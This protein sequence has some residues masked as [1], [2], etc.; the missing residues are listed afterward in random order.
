M[1]WQ[2]GE[3]A[4]GWSDVIW[5]LMFLFIYLMLM[6]EALWNCTHMDVN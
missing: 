1:T 3:V 2:V 6:S 4:L 5:I